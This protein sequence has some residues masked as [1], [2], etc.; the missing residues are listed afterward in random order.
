MWFGKS[1]QQRREWAHLERMKCLERGLPLPDADLA[2]VA[3]LKQRGEQLTGIMIVGTLGLTGGPV[4]TTAILL[5]LGRGLPAFLQVLLLVLVWSAC[6]GT[7]LFLLRHGL[8]ALMSLRR[9]VL[10][11]TARPSLTAE[12]FT[13]GPREEAV[14]GEPS[15]AIQT[16]L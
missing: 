4:A 12:H 8:A 16:A 15:Q 9:E 11:P 13:R 2:W 3:V 5:S 10:A 6:A 7:L 14:R 1:E